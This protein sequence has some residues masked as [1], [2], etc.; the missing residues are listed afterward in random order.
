MYLSQHIIRTGVRFCVLFLFAA[1]ACNNDNDQKQ[2]TDKHADKRSAGG[3][4]KWH[5]D[6]NHRQNEDAGYAQ[7]VKVGNT[8]YVSGIPT[9][10]LSPK[11]I[12]QV[13]GD[14]G[15]CLSANGASFADVVK[16]TLYTTDI[17]TMK[18][19]N[20]V[21][22]AFYKGD[23]PAATWVQI[24]RLY[25]PDCKLEVELIAQLSDDK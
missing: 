4:Q 14:L 13:Y 20:D 7:V 16:E 10:D 17:E 18:K 9:E 24:S 23:F 3:K 21:R 22:K 15:K 2:H 11:G 25:E 1:F 5:W 19:Y 8:L 6:N 12:A